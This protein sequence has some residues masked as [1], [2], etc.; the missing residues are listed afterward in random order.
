MNKL[1]YGYIKNYVESF[2]D[3]KLVT[4]F[5]KK[6]PI[7]IDIQCYCGNIYKTRFNT[8]QQGCRCPLHRYEKS[9]KSRKTCFDKITN[10][11][12]NNGFEILS[13][14][15]DYK[16]ADSYL[17]V[18][19]K[20]G[21]IR[22]VTWRSFK[23]HGGCKICDSENRKLKPGYWEKWKLLGQK[24]TDKFNEARGCTLAES[25]DTWFIYRRT[26][27]KMSERSYNRY[28]NIINPDDLPRGRHLYHLDHKF[29]VLDGFKNNIAPYVLANPTNLQMLSESKNI[30]K[31]YHSEINIDQLFKVV[32]NDN[33]L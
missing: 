18:R 24:R 16:N 27:Y 12:R 1:T 33:R 8:F 13:K 28:K 10:L 21:H 4:P 9:G 22:K 32:S 11:V 25:K 2:K 17:T 5:F 3:Q 26:V 30:A 6:M 29:S 31:D 14:A 7:K 23:L 15:E 20:Q 19:C